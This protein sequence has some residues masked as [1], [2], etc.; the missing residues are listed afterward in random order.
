MKHPAQRH[1]INGAAVDT[2]PD[3]PTRESTNSKAQAC[4]KS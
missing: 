3:D 4:E 1:S 2:K